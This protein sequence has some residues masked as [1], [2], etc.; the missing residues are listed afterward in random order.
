MR[1]DMAKVLCEEPRRGMRVKERKGYK[2]ELARTPLEDQSVKERG[3]LYQRWHAKWGDGKEFGEHLNPLKRFILSSCGRPWNEVYSEI[4]KVV[5]PGNVVNNH[6]YTHLYGYVTV[7]VVEKDG[8]FYD[9]VSSKYG[10]SRIYTPTFV[11][12]ETG[13]LTRTPKRKRTARRRQRTERVIRI[14]ENTA[15]ASEKKGIWYEC[16]LISLS[17]EKIKKRHYFSS[18]KNCFIYTES[19]L[20]Y[21]DIFLK[22]HINFSDGFWR[23][24]PAYCV[25]KRQMNKREIKKI[26]AS[27]QTTRVRDRY[28]DLL[29]IF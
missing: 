18:R 21:Y 5:K 25:S 19:Y 14:N 12:P 3:N 23:S 26:E 15:Y 16:K 27:R 6:L 10:K 28:K 20:S 8:E 4:R 17:K 9:P 1:S 29:K 22:R 11:H 24:P 2:R 13:I 7:N